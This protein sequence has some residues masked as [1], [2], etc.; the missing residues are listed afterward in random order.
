MV[1]LTPA[2]VF[3]WNDSE[4]LAETIQQWSVDSR[5]DEFVAY[6]QDA[7]LR[8]DVRRTAEKMRQLY[9]ELATGAPV[10]NKISDK[11]D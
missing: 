2:F 1:E 11:L 9:S 10:A 3:N 8:F 5:K 7:A 6:A 4:K